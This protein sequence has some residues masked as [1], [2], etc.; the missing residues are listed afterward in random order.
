MPERLRIVVA[1]GV[2][3]MP[4]AGVAWQV[5]QYL[6]GF[7]R[8]GHE[9]F[10]LEDTQRWPYDPLEDTVCDDAGPAITYVAGLMSRC[11]LE[12]AWG[13]RDVA[14]DGTLHGASEALLA[15][16][17]RDADVLVNLSGVTVLR[18]EHL[19]VPV[20]VYLETDPVL[21]Q[22]EVAQGRPFTIE[23]LAAHTHHFSYGENFGAPDCG[24]PLERFRYLPTRPPVILD[25]WSAQQPRTMDGLTF[26]TIANWRQTN[27]DIEWEGRKLTWSKDVEL[28]RFLPLASQAS[29][30]IELA[31]ALEDEQVIAQLREAGW[32]VRRA[33]PLSKDI[34]AYRDYI[35][36]SA[37]EFS[38]AKEQNVK[39]RSGW[40][41]DRTASYL[42]AGRPAILQDTGFGCALP[43]GEGLFAFSTLEQALEALDAVQS[44]YRRHCQAAQEIAEHY[45]RAETVL[46]S[47]LAALDGESDRAG[48]AEPAYG[49]DNSSSR[50]ALRRASNFSSASE[51]AR[52]H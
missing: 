41:S 46:G 11:G 30:P 7:R 9:V 2:G 45:L 50:A 6:E 8:L 12:R 18:E 40:F 28:M 17:L 39:L 5:T 1:G 44:D 32:R 29:V 37:G 24:V 10:Y 26:T 13:Y 19:P 21:P 48:G 42:A 23:F 31:L 15:R 38:V 47:L 27:K 35:R 34:D 14:Q 25:W 20:R 43:T 49:R 51:R 52:E 3:A 16:T 36:C 33:G 4:F 22:I